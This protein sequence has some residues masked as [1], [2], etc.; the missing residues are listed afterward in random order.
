MSTQVPAFILEDQLSRGQPCR[1]YCTEPRRISAVSLAQ[2][3]SRE[4]GDPP[5]TVGTLNSLVGYAIRLESNTT[6]NTRLTYITTGIA[7]RM[8]ERGSGRGGQG[9]AFD[10]I[11]HII[12]DEVHERTIESDFLL[13]VLRSLLL[14]RP[15][16]RVILMSATADSDKIS[17]Y[18]GGC[19]IIHVPGRTFP[20][21]VLYLEDAIECTGWSI[22]ED[23]PY[24]KRRHSK[25]YQRK[26]RTDWDEP[27]AIDED[28]D[29]TL[30]E[31]ESSV[32]ISVSVEKRYSPLTERTVELLD[33]RAIPYDLIV[34]LLEHSCFKNKSF[35]S[36]SAILIF[37]PGL[38]EIRRMIDLLS[39]HP[40]F[41]QESLFRVYPLHSTL[42]SENQNAVFDV[43]PAGTRKI[44][45]ATNIAETGITIPDITCVID[46]GKQ[47]EIMYLYLI[48]HGRGTNNRSGSTK[49]VN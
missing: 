39:D 7:L 29:A 12:I 42:S 46:S 15:D 34:R 43:P 30:V 4:L 36:F 37:M 40:S 23:S 20:V 2:R 26:G 11:T 41:G 21:D 5:G 1:I 33:E 25:F 35:L 27:T 8:L 3:V 47:R 28:E 24:A 14:Q 45:V 22:T 44:V 6:K 31:G 19:P 38:A 16:L 13:V 10:D 18:F 49:S 17:S 9:T 32:N 48:L